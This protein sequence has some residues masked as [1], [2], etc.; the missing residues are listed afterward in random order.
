[1]WG[2][3][4]MN[5]RGLCINAGQPGSDLTAYPDD[6]AML[7]RRLTGGRVDAGSFQRPVARCEIASCRGMCC[8]DGV[9]LSPESASVVQHASVQHAHFFEG[10]G[11][12]LPDPIIVEGEWAWKKG[13]LK[14][15]VTPR[16]FSGTVRGF[17]PHFNDTSC[18]FLTKDGLCALQLL[19][20]QLGR[21][22]WFYKPVKCWMHPITLEGD[23]NSV[24]TLHDDRTDPYRLPG[25]DGFV[26]RIFCG[27]TCPGGKP[28]AAVLSDELSFLSRIVG[29][30]LLAEAE[31]KG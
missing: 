28:A 15:A 1:V 3:P 7:R 22:P 5:D 26:S 8:Y 4:G 23:E 20:Q 25:Y 6:E 14:T 30:D 12:R 9:Y 16:T 13:G 21:H 24:L 29:R 18:A 27:K 17:P 2:L 19:S 11:L 10:L 31:G